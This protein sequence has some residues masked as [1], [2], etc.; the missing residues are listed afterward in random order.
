MI[1]LELVLIRPRTLRLTS[2]PLGNRTMLGFRGALSDLLSLLLSLLMKPGIGM[3]GMG[4]PSKYLVRFA[5]G[6]VTEE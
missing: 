2:I 1:Q 5:N 6:S 3:E 4:I